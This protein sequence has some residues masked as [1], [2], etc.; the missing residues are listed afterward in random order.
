MSDQKLKLGDTEKKETAVP[1]ETASATPAIFKY[2]EYWLKR[3]MEDVEATIP[4]LQSRM[5]GF[6]TYLNT[7]SGATLLGGVT[8]TTLTDTRDLK[9]FILIFIAIGGLQLVKYL[10]GIEKTKP[11]FA[12]VDLRSPIQI[13]KAHNAFVKDLTNSLKDAKGLVAFATILYLI[14]VPW[15]IYR[16]NVLADVATEN[17]KLVIANSQ[18]KVTGVF[19]QDTELVLKLKGDQPTKMV[20]VIVDSVKSNVDTTKTNLPIKNPIVKEIKTTK[21]VKDSLLIALKAKKGASFEYH[22]HLED[23]AF[24]PKEVELRAAENLLKKVVIKPKKKGL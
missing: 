17:P 8:L 24:M 9:V 1:E 20:G 4:G 11:S 22:V 7:L 6:I 18:V 14:C 10:I 5:Q 12:K 2:D 21:P 16:N 15:A 13:N 23:V 3:G 19:A